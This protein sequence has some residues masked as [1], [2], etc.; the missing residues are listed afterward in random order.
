MQKKLTITVSEDVYKGLH[1]KIGRGQISSFIDSLARPH[2]VDDAL[3]AAYED[4]ALDEDREQEALSWSEA[5]LDDI[6][7]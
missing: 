1:A 3:Y 4:M 2:V 5:L 6:E 7:S